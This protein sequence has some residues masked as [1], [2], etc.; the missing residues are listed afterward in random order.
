[1]LY[2]VKHFGAKESSKELRAR[3]EAAYGK[4]Y[5]P[6]MVANARRELK[7]PE[8]KALKARNEKAA[9]KPAPK[10]EVRVVDS[11]LAVPNGAKVALAKAHL[12]PAPKPSA[13]KGAKGKK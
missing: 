5:R 9:E 10:A 12:T 3:V 4:K 2:V 6:G 1:V 8:T 11:N 13:K 7:V